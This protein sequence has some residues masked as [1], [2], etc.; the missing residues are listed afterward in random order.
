M[1][2][3]YHLCY[4]ALL[5]LSAHW[6]PCAM[7]IASRVSWFSALSYL[8]CMLHFIPPD[9]KLGH[10]LRHHAVED[11]GT[12]SQTLYLKPPCWHFHCARP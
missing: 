1:R 3:S 8:L 10:T 5:Y 7:V 9:T 2:L 6:L 11:H 4:K 12:L